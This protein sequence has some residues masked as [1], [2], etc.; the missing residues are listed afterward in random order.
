MMTRYLFEAHDLSKLASVLHRQ[1][2]YN[3]SH[4]C[5]VAK[6]LTYLYD[7]PEH[8]KIK[9]ISPELRAWAKNNQLIVA[10]PRGFVSRCDPLVH[11]EFYIES[12]GW[13]LYVS[14]ERPVDFQGTHFKVKLNSFCQIPSFS[15]EAVTYSTAVRLDPAVRFDFDI[16]SLLVGESV[17]ES[18]PNFSDIRDFQSN[19]NKSSKSEFENIIQQ[20]LIEHGMQ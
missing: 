5:E 6:K 18:A 9:K 20:K 3:T 11:Q 12:Y 14:V 16:L 19:F 13:P 2:L 10:D 7:L 17:A 1:T 4:E 15:I 8:T